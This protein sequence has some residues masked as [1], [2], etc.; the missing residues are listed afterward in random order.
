MRVD[1]S[2]V[3]D[4][5]RRG[6]SLGFDW[7]TDR[8]A[9]AGT[10]RRRRLALELE[11]LDRALESGERAAIEDEVGDVMIVLVS[12]AL[13]RGADPERALDGAVAK[14]NRRLDFVVGCGG[15][16]PFELSELRRRWAEAK[17]RERAANTAEGRG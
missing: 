10:T 16:G 13:A 1:L 5:L 17:A 7:L 14:V 4:L 6:A 8:A 11:E 15:H 3:L 9:N 12:L 2:P